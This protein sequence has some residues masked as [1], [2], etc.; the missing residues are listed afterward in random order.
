MASDRSRY[1][2]FLLRLWKADNGGQPVWRLSLEEAGRRRRRRFHSLEE[3][4]A[5]L[6]HLM[7]EKRLDDDPFA[8]N[9][10]S[11]DD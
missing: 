11:E 2:A 6:L 1:R 4:D 5:F 9:S 7:R 8:D 10:F 3:L